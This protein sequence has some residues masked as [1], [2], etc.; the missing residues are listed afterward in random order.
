MRQIVRLK[1]T[2]LGSKGLQIFKRQKLEN[3]KLLRTLLVVVYSIQSL[4][5][6]ETVICH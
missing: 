2:M 3:K 5:K 1:K 6:L 4:K